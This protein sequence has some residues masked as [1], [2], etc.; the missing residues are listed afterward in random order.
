MIK[1]GYQNLY[2]YKSP[3]MGNL[4]DKSTWEDQNE[5]YMEQNL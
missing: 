1:P 2:R 3:L 4:I 5:I